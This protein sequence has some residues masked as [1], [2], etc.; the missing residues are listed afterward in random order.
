MANHGG[1][2]SLPRAHR[3]RAPIMSAAP[4]QTAPLAPLRSPTTT[5]TA[6]TPLPTV[7]LTLPRP[8]NERAANEYVEAPFRAARPLA[9]PTRPA[10]LALPAPVSKQPAGGGVASFSK[11]PPPECA[12]TRSIMCPRCGRC[13]CDSCQQPRPLPHKWVFGNSC[14]V[15]ADSLIDYVSCLCCVKGMYYHC[16][17]AEGGESCA[18]D[19]CACAPHRRAARWGCLAALSCVLPCLWLYWPLRG[20][21][22]VAEECYARHSRTGCRCGPAQPAHVALAATTPEKRLLDS[23]PE[24]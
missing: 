2:T 20:C 1:A 16:G 4:P 7:S 13:R 17:D 3:P 22:R 11:D 18:D 5:T 10:R 8:H 9:P 12:A 24:F 23:S 14:L 15:S 19:P 6:T 21:K